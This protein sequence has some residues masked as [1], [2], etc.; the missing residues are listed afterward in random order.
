MR[1]HEQKIVVNGTELWVAS[2]GSGVPVILCNGGPG[3]GDYM[4]PVASMIDDLARVYRFEPRGCGRS[5]AAGPYDLR[6]SL[7]DLDG[8]RDHLGHERWVVGGH[9]WG[10][11][12]ALAYALEYAERTTAVVYLSGTGIQDDRQWHDA[13]EA[14]RAAGREQ[15]LDF[16]YQPNVVVNRAGNA[17]SRDYIKHPLL[18]RR[19]AEL[20]VPVFAVYGSADIRPG[21]PVEQLINLLPNARFELIRCWPQS[22]AD[23]CRTAPRP[24]AGVSHRAA[25]SWR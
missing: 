3:C 12:L 16:A 22:M 24:V 23:A 10:A 11:F 20:T 14:G 25:A 19:I 13:Y 5:S 2:Q 15:E 6:T 1:A 18:L 7:E 21:W 17:S 9:S 4:S 8:L